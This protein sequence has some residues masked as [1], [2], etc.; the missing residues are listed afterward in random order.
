MKYVIYVLPFLFFFACQEEEQQKET[1]V[2]LVRHAEKDTT[3]KSDN[4]PL[5]PFGRQQAKDFT[6]IVLDRGLSV[7]HFYS[8]RF[9][10][11][12]H[13][14]QP[15]ADHFNKD[16]GIYEWKEW[17][18][19]A[20]KMKAQGGTSV[21]C[22]HGDNLLPIIKHYNGVPPLEKLGSYENDKLFFIT[23]K[24]DTALVEMIAY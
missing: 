4:P 20:D 16:I 5:T 11:N 14:V 6:K 18:E 13:T 12:I 2:I 1:T 21:F 17:H 9:D 15:L 7:D 8:T 22:G 24:E 3:D 19:A 10:R 23:V